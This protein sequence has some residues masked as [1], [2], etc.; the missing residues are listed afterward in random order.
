M[1]DQ[2]HPCL[3][4]LSRQHN[5]YYYFIQ[6]LLTILYPFTFVLRIVLVIP[7][8]ALSAFIDYLTNLRTDQTKPLSNIRRSIY[9]IQKA[10]LYRTALFFCGWILVVKG[11]PSQKA[12]ALMS[13]HSSM[14]DILVCTASGVESC[15]SKAGIANNKLFGPTIRVTRSILARSGGATDEIIKR[16]SEDGWPP[17]GVFP[18]G[19]T[20]VQAATPKMRTGVFVS[21]P[22]IQLATIK[23]NSLEN[24]FYTTG[25][26]NH[27]IG[28][29]RG[30]FGLITLEFYDEVYQ[31]TEEE[32]YH[33]YADRV[34]QNLAQNLNSQLT[35]YSFKDS[36]W[37]SGNKS[38]SKEQ[39]SEDYQNEQL[40]RGNYEQWTKLCKQKHKNPM[41]AWS[42]EQLGILD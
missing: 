42:K 26:K 38:V 16:F 27:I 41:F 18:A 22:S 14:L 6:P 20:T 24:P 29:T 35:T 15:I 36:V 32:D 7:L 37:F 8:L 17:L 33:N 1:V 13:N 12:K 25:P 34:G 19:T 11:K 5:V 10:I 9:R 23:Y 28:V 31:A 3:L 2:P 21:K 30:L 39:L 40:W 4:P